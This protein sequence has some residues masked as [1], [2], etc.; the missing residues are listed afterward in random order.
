[1]GMPSSSIDRVRRDQA[2][3]HA[4]GGLPAPFGPRKPK[5]QPR[6]CEVQSIDG[7]LVSVHLSQILTEIAVD[8]LSILYRSASTHCRRDVMG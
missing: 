2:R 1:M 4:D 8:E 3:Q 6:D 7:R 5:K